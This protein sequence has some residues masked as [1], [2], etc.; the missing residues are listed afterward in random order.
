MRDAV[1]VHDQ[2]NKAGEAAPGMAC[3]V[4]RGKRRQPLPVSRDD[5][6]V[7]RKQ[8]EQRA[9]ENQFRRTEALRGEF[10][11]HAHEREQKAGDQHPG[12]F[13]LRN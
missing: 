2:R 9:V 4:P 13:H 6:D 12:G 3:R 8:P 1:K 5:H 11:Q 7:D 10:D